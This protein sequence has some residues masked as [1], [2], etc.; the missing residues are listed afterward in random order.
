MAHNGRRSAPADGG[1]GMVDAKLDVDH[2]AAAAD[3]RSSDRGAPAD[4]LSVDLT[5]A[6]VLSSLPDA[7][8]LLEEHGRIVLVNSRAVHLF[9]FA[10]VE[11][12]NRP[13]DTV[14]PNA[15]HHV[16]ARRQEL[17]G[18][19][20]AT[21]TSSPT[22]SLK[23]A[24]VHKDGTVLALEVSL[25]RLDIGGRRLALCAIHDATEHALA[26]AAI[27]HSEA[28]FNEAQRIAKIGSW[29]LDVASN[30][31]WWS[32]ELYRM[33]GIDHTTVQRPFDV[34]VERLHPDDRQR[35][36]DSGA[37]ALGGQAA[38]VE[39]RVVLP[40]GAERVFYSR[41][42][43]TFDESNR[44]VRMFGTLQDITERK[45]FQAALSLT[46][47]RY[48]EAQRIARIGNWEWDIVTNKS[49]WS[50]ELY[51][52]FEADP[53]TYEASFE[54]FMRIVHPDD[55]RLVEHDR[56]NI[57]P[58]SDAYRP[59]EVRLKFA[60]GREKVIEQIIKVRMGERGQPVAVVGTVH[61]VTERR[62]L[63]RQL[64]ESE[65]RYA[66]TVELAAVGIAHV[67][68]G[69][70]LIWT[71]GKLREM[72]GFS[73]EELQGLTIRDLSH[74]DDVHVTDTDRAR[75]HA[76]EISS[77][78]AEKRYLRRDGTV[79]WVRITS[80]LRRS[81]EG[82][83][84]YDVSVVEDIT[85]RK[86]AEDRVQFLATHDELT[87]LPNR[88]VFTE[89][90]DHAIQSAHRHNRQCALLF[91]DLD[92]FKIVND[93]LGHE[94]GDRLLERMAIRLGGCMRQSDV[95]ARLGGDEFVVLL[96]QLTDP[97]EA[98]DVARKMLSS[99]LAPVEIM[100]H[101]CR[102]TASIG[103]AIY[104]ADARD[105]QTLMKNADMAMYLAKEEGKNNFQ[106]YSTHSSPMSVER[107]VLET[108]LSRALE[109]NEFTVQYQPK[110]DMR[111]GEIKGAEALLR[112][113][114]PELGTVSPTQF[115][116]VAED[117]GLIV[118]IGKWVLKTACEQSV[119]WQKRGLRPI[120]MSVNMSPRQFKDPALLDDIAEVLVETGV[121]PDLLELEITESMIMHNV[122]LAA[123][124][125]EAIR[126]LG[127]RLAIDDFGTGYSS[128]SQLKRFPIDTLKVDRSFV[129]DI[130]TNAEDRAITE[131]I[132]ALGKALGVTVVA[133]G[134][135]TVEQRDF[136]RDNAC[137]E[138]Q[139]FYFSR[140]CH[141]DAIAELLA[142]APVP[143]T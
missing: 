93:S 83:P 1:E 24:G 79:I 91:I 62:A 141:P 122:E 69:G 45:A 2:E 6:A 132:I 74:K 29:E 116:P 60:D 119:A 129:R 33:V 140:P 41:G 65:S 20:A 85:D 47:L 30:R 12:L 67:D 61:D 39:V 86:R 5:V 59:T 26:L 7:V 70:R 16:A 19:T 138:M 127:V 11:L 54:N 78:K 22:S 118:A 134:V 42:E 75:L 25:R 4:T 114:N 15:R 51:R 112:W 97:T 14:I 128:L 46:D 17:F 104:P 126:K 55:H 90:L 107:L 87:G 137:D 96:E 37:R 81:P 99:V 105:S 94:A 101:E 66:S 109:R 115:I 143:K 117:S 133:E 136:L 57:A 53:A 58:E 130:T 76:G 131:T 56:N 8:L 43:V 89:L 103:I 18:P 21:Q 123:M 73:V 111:T 98:S 63:E 10:T 48:R 125:T 72:L 28:R 31:H 3:E 113:W 82:Q 34:F 52:I 38:P 36:L 27:T 77:L 135:E 71:N 120:V 142:A 40:D 108:H 23:I 49:W 9:G 92:R 121:R 106:F 95:L 44:P 88:A 68:H 32:D 102:V 100:G 64:R 110:V 139:G 80:A 84:L 35:F 124:K 13:I 50:D